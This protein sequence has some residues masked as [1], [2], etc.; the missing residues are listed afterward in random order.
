MGLRYAVGKLK[1]ATTVQA[2]SVAAEQLL[3]AGELGRIFLRKMVR[4]E[5]GQHLATALD[6]LQRENSWTALPTV[7][8]RLVGEADDRAKSNLAAAAGELLEHVPPDERVRF[9]GPLPRLY[10]SVADDEDFSRTRSAGV[11]VK[12]FPAWWQSDGRAMDRFLGVNYASAYLEGYLQVASESPNE[13]VR[14]W[15]LSQLVAFAAHDPSLKAWWTFDNAVDGLVPDRSGNGH[16]GRISGA[17]LQPGKY[18]RALKFDG[19]DDF[20]RVSDTPA[21]SGGP[22]AGLTV[23]V[24]FKLDE[25]AGYNGLVE[26][27]WDGTTGDWGLYAQNG[28]LSYYSEATGNDF[29]LAGGNVRPDQWHHAVFTMKQTDETFEL[30]MFLDG[31][32]SAART[33]TAAISAETPG[34]VFF[35]A[36]MYNNSESKGFGKPW[37]DDIRIYRRVMPAEEV[38]LLAPGRY[39]GDAH[40]AAKPEVVERLVRQLIDLAGDG[41][42]RPRILAAAVGRAWRSVGDGQRPAH[43]PA[44]R[45]YTAFV[46]TLRDRGL[47]QPFLE[48]PVN[49]LVADWFGGDK[50]AFQAWHAGTEDVAE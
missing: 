33:A 31:E 3:E 11:F 15:G 10:T 20:V 46:Q 16:A 1:T 40:T 5:H 49:T 47:L 29:H 38:R 34:D 44:A 18:G 43:E 35:G 42:M 32:G 9:A 7:L 2:K 41:T 19:K 24:V 36:R 23:S 6:L 48:E 50:E 13:E 26:T 4:E 28:R 22:G 30:R 21:L 14:L 27:Q 12:L 17:I 39:L 25:V 8:E 45:R 37:I